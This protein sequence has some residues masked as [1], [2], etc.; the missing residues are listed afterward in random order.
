ML[1]GE[2][3]PTLAVHAIPGAGTDVPLWILGSSTFGAQLAGILGLPYAFASH[4]APD[5]LMRALA[6]YRQRFQPSKQLEKPY[7]MVGL[8]VVAAD[9]DA[10]AQRLFTSVLQSNTNHLRNVR[11]PQQPPIDDI[12][13]YWTPQEKLQVM[14]KLQYAV[15]GSRETV[16]AGLE[17]LIEQT[18]ADELMVVTAVY[19]HA[20]RVRSLEILAEVG[21]LA[22]GGTEAGGRRG[23]KR[24]AYHHGDG[25]ATHARGRGGASDL[26]APSPRTGPREGAWE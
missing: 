4:F 23:L 25:A 1:L 7:A 21:G 15:V 20:A 14:H 9:T 13:S 6:F 16:R 19:E 17:Q 8:H 22:G 5:E 18:Q 12:E 26:F 3:D 24:P 11:G 10:E 2:F